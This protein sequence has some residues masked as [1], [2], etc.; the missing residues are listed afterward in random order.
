MCFLG[1]EFNVKFDLFTFLTFFTGFIF[2][3]VFLTLFY[4]LICLISLNK[5]EK[6][7]KKSNEEVSEEKISEI[8]KNTQKD[9]LK[10]RKSSTT[11]LALKESVIN[12][13][14][15]IAKE[16]Y[17]NSNHPI[18]ELSIEELIILDR[19]IVNKIEEILSSK[20][21]RLLKNI[22]ITTILNIVDANN[23]IQTNKVVKL[24]KKMHFPKIVKGINMALN[25]IN[26]F[27][28]FKRLVISPSLNFLI[29]KIL[30]LTIS[31]VGE[32]VYKVYSKKIFI[33]DE[34]EVEKLLTS[35]ENEE[36]IENNV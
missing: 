11:F 16:Y 14:N 13:V 1:V 10:Q 29:K 3:I 34:E 23:K 33:T 36:K 8:I 5:K 35:L 31:I 12:L 6:M 15:N 20:G 17:P 19:Y 25:I 32:E 2:G 4:V 9:F 7:I 26:P 24:S 22:R 27:Y 18:G 28:W 21:L 30:L